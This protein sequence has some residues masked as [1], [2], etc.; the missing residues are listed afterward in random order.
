M[1]YYGFIVL[2]LGTVTLEIDNL[3]PTNLKFLEGAFYQWYSAILDAFGI[4]FLA[5]SLGGD[6][7]L[8][9]A[10][11]AGC[12]PRPS[13]RTL[14][15]GPCSRSSVSPDSLVEAARIALDGRPDFETWSFVGYPLSG[16]PRRRRSASTR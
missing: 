11:V 3:A 16:V 8:G 10:A 5:G 7:S 6:P 14:D 9:A 4:V 13:P 15:P 12:A 2:F 1:I